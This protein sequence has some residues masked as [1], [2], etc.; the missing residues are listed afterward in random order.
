MPSSCSKRGRQSI[1][2]APT[3]L[4]SMTCKL[5]HSTYCC[6]RLI[7][8]PAWDLTGYLDLCPTVCAVLLR[9]MQGII[10]AD[11]VSLALQA[12]D[13]G[14][15]A[16]SSTSSLV[17]QPQKHFGRLSSWRLVRYYVVF[18]PHLHP[19]TWIKTSDSKQC[20]GALLVYLHLCPSAMQRV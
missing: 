15:T 16:V 11:L 8:A 19:R 10:F 12:S 1:P 2:V 3:Q 14:A 9:A 20:T 5:S 17:H 4:C 6:V 7:P 18:W 13:G